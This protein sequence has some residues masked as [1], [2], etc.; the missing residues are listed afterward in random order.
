MGYCVCVCVM[1]I[2]IIMS[3]ALLRLLLQQL[4]SHHKV[5]VCYKDWDSITLHCKEGLCPNLLGFL[6]VDLSSQTLQM[7]PS[8]GSL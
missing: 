6:C 1:V 2:I 8:K 5:M 3:I 4:C 7:R